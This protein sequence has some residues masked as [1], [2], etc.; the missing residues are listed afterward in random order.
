MS[1]HIIDKMSGLVGGIESLKLESEQDLVVLNN[2]VSQLSE[3]SGVVNK[4][5]AEVIKAVNEN[6]DLARVNEQ[7][8]SAVMEI[9]QYLLL[10]PSQV[11]GKINVLHAKLAAYETCE[12]LIADTVSDINSHQ[13]KVERI[14]AKIEDG[15]IE[16]S[17]GVG[18]RPEKLRDVR[19]IMSE[20][21]AEKSAE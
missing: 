15:S 20:I 21:E 6:E 1:D 4:F 14:K 11:E 12:T 10:R 9:R 16:E 3:A 5:I 7:L 8:V 19:N 2:S 13:E 18:E 17:R